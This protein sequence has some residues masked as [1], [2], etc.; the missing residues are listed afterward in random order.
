[1]LEYRLIKKEELEKCAEICAGAYLDYE[2]FSIFVKDKKKLF[3][4]ILAIM[5]T[6]LNAGYKKQVVLVGVE[7]GQI[8]SAAQ[9]KK[10]NTKEL[11]FGSCILS[12]ALRIFSAGGV[13]STIEWLKMSEA[14]EQACRQIPEPRWYLNSFIVAKDHQHEGIGCSMLQNCVIPYIANH[15]GGPLTLVTNSEE[16]SEFYKKNGFAEFCFEHLFYM[17]ADLGNWSF[18]KEIPG[19]V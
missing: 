13:K 4:F 12:G 8:V 16:N 7:Q 3:D 2:Y 6:A 18:K 17:N 15:G 10:P 1:M 9:L 5:R 14:S 19:A 11:S